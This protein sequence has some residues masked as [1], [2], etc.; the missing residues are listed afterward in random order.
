MY[1]A[2]IMMMTIIIIVLRALRAL[3]PCDPKPVASWCIAHGC[4]VYGGDFLVTQQ[5]QQQ[6]DKRILGIRMIV[7][8]SFADYHK[9]EKTKCM[10]YFQQKQNKGFYDE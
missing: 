9:A 2:I 4:I 10:Q 8:L 3:R 7:I 6:Q 5:Q 1:N